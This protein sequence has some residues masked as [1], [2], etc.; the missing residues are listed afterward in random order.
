M[1]LSLRTSQ[2]SSLLLVVVM[3]VEVLMCLSSATNA[4]PAKVSFVNYSEGPITVKWVDANGDKVTIGTI[5]PYGQAR[6]SASRGHTFLYDLP[7]G[8]TVQ[9][10]MSGDDVHAI[11]IPSQI[12]VLCST[13]KGDLRITVKPKWSPLGAARFLELLRKEF[14]NY[15]VGE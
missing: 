11:Q 13:T 7:N 10:V 6:S 2:S 8:E 14:G 15:Q 1:L 4:Q 3:V 5:E 9:Y 12:S